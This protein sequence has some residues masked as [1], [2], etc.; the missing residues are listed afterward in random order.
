MLIALDATLVLR[1]GAER[2]S[3]P[4][5]DF[6][7]GYRRTALVPGE[8]IERI[9]V[10]L[11]QPGWQFRCYKVAKRFDQDISAVCGAFRVAIDGGPRA[12]HPHRLRR[13]GGHAR[14]APA[15]RSK[16][17]WG[18]RGRR[19]ACKRRWHAL[20]TEFSPISDMRAGAAYRR[21]VA[22]NLLY[23]CFLETCAPEPMRTRLTVP[24]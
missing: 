5:E 3:L 17:C 8:F 4:L 16:C 11:P 18:R 20:D 2:R 15:A 1:R 12:R 9:D 22:R 14:R 23:K 13:H 6:F 19:R 21:M 7:L 24:A 10:P